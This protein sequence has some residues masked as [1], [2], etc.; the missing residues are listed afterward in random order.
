MADPRH[1]KLDRWKRR[2]YDFGEGP[3]PSVTTLIK[4][5][6]S[7][8]LENWKVRRAIDRTLSNMLREHKVV[9]LQ[10]PANEKGERHYSPIVNDICRALDAPGAAAIRGTNV[11]EALEEWFGTGTTPESLTEEERPYVEQAI[12]WAMDYNPRPIYLEPETMGDGYGGSDDWIMDIPGFGVTLGDYKT[13]GVFESAA[14]QLAAY[15][16]SKRLYPKVDAPC[17]LTLGE[18]TCTCEW[19]PMPKID[20]LA[21]L[22]LKPDRYE[23]TI[24]RPEA[25]EKAWQAFQGCLAQ[26]ALKQTKVIFVPAQSLAKTA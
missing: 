17:S 19:I 22:D 2:N 21:V 11:H 25:A 7:R 8:P 13:G 6:Y 12:R 1:A 24:V 14:M 18:P 16:H 20:H 5:M 15:L 26:H 4:Q 3:L 23:M 9:H 10:T